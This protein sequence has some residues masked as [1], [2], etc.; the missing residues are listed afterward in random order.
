MGTEASG[1]IH[2][3]LACYHV[4]VL[5]L[6]T[7]RS[8]PVFTILEVAPE[9]YAPPGLPKLLQKPPKDGTVSHRQRTG[10]FM[11]VL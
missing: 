11:D 6:R 4:I 7:I 2:G 8:D 9:F 1:S 3:K 10:K 5:V